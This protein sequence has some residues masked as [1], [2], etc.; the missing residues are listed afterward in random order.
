MR[1]FAPLLLATAVSGMAV[2]SYTNLSPFASKAL[3]IVEKHPI[4]QGNKY[5]DWFGQGDVSCE[6]AKDLVVQFSVFSNLFLLAQLNKIINSQTLEDM[7]EGKEILANEIGV[8]FKP[9]NKKTADDGFDP[10]VVGVSGS[11]VGGVYNHR[12]AHFEWLVDVGK[13]LGLTFEQ[14]GKRRHGTEKTLHFC[15]ELFRI[16]GNDDPNIALGASFAIEHWANAGFWDDLV[17]GFTKMNKAGTVK[18]P[19]GFWKF[20]QALEAQH[21]S[22]TMDELEEAYAEGRVTDEALFTQGANEMLDACA[23]FWEGLEETRLELEK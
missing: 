22:H 20:H 5:C 7:R 8:V 6:Q 13:P 15:D 21:A 17:D 10:N 18:T 2:S 16:Y 3:S 19:I 23:V 14:M 12:A 9:P 4:V 1:T 11:V